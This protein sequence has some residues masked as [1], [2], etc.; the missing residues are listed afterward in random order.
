MAVK[1]HSS[2]RT[3]PAPVQRNEAPASPPKL[4]AVPTSTRIKFIE[5]GRTRS[6]LEGLL[7]IGQS[8]PTL[9]RHPNTGSMV[10]DMD[11]EA[12]DEI[13]DDLMNTADDVINGMKLSRS[14]D[15][16]P[17]PGRMRSQRQ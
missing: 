9:T 13:V 10:L 4:A 16:R 14:V 8:L 6:H 15:D 3:P 11:G 17:G 5:V 7:T 12:R 1:K 2:K